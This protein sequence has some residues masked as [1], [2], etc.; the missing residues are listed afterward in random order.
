[1]Q[2]Q[3]NTKKTHL[4]LSYVDYENVHSPYIIKLNLKNDSIQTYDRNL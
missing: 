4:N 2:Q 1:M 3:K